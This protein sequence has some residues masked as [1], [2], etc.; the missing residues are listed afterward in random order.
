[1]NGPDHYQQAERFLDGVEDLIKHPPPADEV[2]DL[3]TA[4]R[5]GLLAAQAHATLAHAAAIALGV[6]D[7]ADA[8]GTAAARAWRKVIL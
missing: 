7:Q 8:P 1:M 4:I 5:D 2:P 6:V 3:E